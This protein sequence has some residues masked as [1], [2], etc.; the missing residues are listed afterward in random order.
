MANNQISQQEAEFQMFLIQNPKYDSDWIGEAAKILSNK[1]N[2][3]TEDDLANFNALQLMV[4]NEILS[5]GKSTEE[6]ESVLKI[7]FIDNANL[8]ATQMRLY[9]V[10]RKNGL[11]EDVMNKFLDPEIPYAKS[12]YAIQA[13]TE[14]F[15]GIIEYL[16]H[17]DASQIAEIYT[18]MKDGIDYKIYAKPQ[19]TAEFMNFIRHAIMTGINL[20]ITAGEDIIIEVNKPEEVLQPA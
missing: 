9:W 12:N 20:Q 10:G 7:L 18:G 13:I 19:Y 8:N 15:T 17:F 5:S 3:F 2:I 11:T 6:I 1:E 16:D 4:M 14:G